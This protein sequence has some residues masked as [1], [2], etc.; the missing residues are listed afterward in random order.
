MAG[1]CGTFNILTRELSGFDG[2]KNVKELYTGEKI[3]WNIPVLF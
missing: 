3:S 2:S 1:F